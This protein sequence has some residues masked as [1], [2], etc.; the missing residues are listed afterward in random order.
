MVLTLML[1]IVVVGWQF[2][3]F[4][5]IENGE[6][7]QVEKTTSHSTAVFKRDEIQKIVNQINARQVNFKELK[8]STNANKYFLI[9]SYYYL[10]KLLKIICD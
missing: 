9:I 1:G 10:A 5:Q 4:N 3:F 8:R 6:V 2:H 7:F